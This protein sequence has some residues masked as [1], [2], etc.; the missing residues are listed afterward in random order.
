M[1]KKEEAA[2]Y[3]DTLNLPKTSF[4]MKAELPIREPKMLKEWEKNVLYNSIIAKRKNS[5]KQFILH[6][7]PPYANGHIHM[8]HV[9]NKILKDI[10]VKYNTMKGCYAPYVPGWDCHGLPVEHQLF[11][12]LNM[13][14]AD[15]G[16]VEFRKKAYKYAMK[17]VK[18]QADE[19]KRL[20]I[21]GDWD[22]PYL[23][24][25]RDYESAILE[26]LGDLYEKGFVYKGL[27]PVNW[28]KTCE[29]ALAEA[30]VEYEDKVSPSIYVKFAAYSE[31]SGKKVNLI[32]WTTTPWTLLANVAVALHPDLEYSYVDV[33][34][35]IWVMQSGL[36]RGI[37]EKLKISN[38]NTLKTLYG[39]E[40]VTDIKK[41]RHPFIERDSVLVTAEYVTCEDG[42]G[43]VHIAPGH[44]QDD[45]FTG[46]KYGL[47]VLVP[48]NNSGKFTKDTGEFSGMDVFAANPVIIEKLRAN[49]TLLMSQDITHSYPHCW[50]CKE[51]IIFRATE[52]WFMGIDRAGLRGKMK[53]A[54][55]KDVEWVPAMGADRIGAMV[56]NRPDWCLSRQRY[57]GVPIPAFVCESCGESFTSAEIIKKVAGEAIKD[58]ADAWF[59]RP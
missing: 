26:A 32:V 41:V 8:G 7:G 19:F 35:E 2:K 42:S 51:P 34:K 12:E 23:T 53:E 20:G 37:L 16:Q 47:E 1:E 15:I 28:C 30:E 50:R 5:G 46:K 38:A 49:G 22:N 11:K 18:I 21:F 40:I 14:K 39:K 10:C 36:S 9:L 17:F 56:E 3:K 24:L 44:G 52:Q 54:I 57:W 25:T 6:D 13:T 59:E 4:P 45:Y 43:C 31:I 29:T 27:K 33:G 55:K 48:V 58:G